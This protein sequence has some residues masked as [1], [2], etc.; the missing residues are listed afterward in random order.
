MHMVS[1]PNAYPYLRYDAP[2]LFRPSKMGP[3]GITHPTCGTRCPA[4]G[5]PMA[6]GQYTTLI[7]L[8][9]GADPEERLKARQRKVYNAVAVELHWGCATGLFDQ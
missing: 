8:G 4:C 3:K 9:P 2:S 1:P 6:A 7:P 5:E